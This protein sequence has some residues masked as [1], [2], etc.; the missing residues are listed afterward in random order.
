MHNMPR[1]RGVFGDAHPDLGTLFDNIRHGDPDVLT[2]MYGEKLGRPLSLLADAIRS[3]IWA[4]PGH[5][6]LAADYSGIEGAVAAW[7]AGEDWKVQALFDLAA[8]PSL[9]DLYRRA[10]ASIFNTSVENIPKKDPR[11]Q[12]GKVS[13]LSLQYQGGPGAFRSM[14]R[15]YSMKLDP[16]YDPVWEA[17]T[18]ERK[19]KAEKRYAT[20]L[21]QKLPIGKQLT[22][23]EFMAA[24][25]VKIGWRA[26]HPRIVAAWDALSD[27]AYDA[28][29]NPGL[30]CHALKGRYLFKAG[31]LWRQLPSGRCLAYGAPR[32]K[33]Q[34][35]VKRKGSEES[36]TLGLEEAEKL[37]ARGELTIESEARPAV[38]V[39]GVNSVTKKWER[40]AL[41]GGLCFENDVQAIARDL[42]AN[43]MKKAE[44][45]GYPNVGHVHDE[46]IAEVPNGFGDIKQF[47][48]L[49]CELPKWAEGL[50]LT[51]SGFRAKRYQK[52]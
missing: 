30:V 8:D 49:I 17:A 29:A 37:Q 35:W 14:A 44:A 1:P 23:R 48:K 6:I 47:E 26:G 34:V 3:F 28:V 40:Y 38:T 52:D 19:A 20:V 39:R 33:R 36:E 5:E 7:Y 46:I 32:V 45:A 2:M 18:D 24:E 10:A 42:L 22:R 51:A 27:A 16:I 11:R 15:N 43:G 25:L 12:V 31:F 13:E 4:A 41:Y 9:P 50:P 21:A